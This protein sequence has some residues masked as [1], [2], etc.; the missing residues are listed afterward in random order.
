MIK[1]WTEEFKIHYSENALKHFAMKL[2]KIQKRQFTQE[3][4]LEFA[5]SICSSHSW[6]PWK[7]DEFSKISI[8]EEEKIICDTWFYTRCTWLWLKLEIFWNFFE[9][10]NWMFN[11]PSKVTLVFLFC[12]NYFGFRPAQVQMDAISI[13]L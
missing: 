4:L 13:S 10:N 2:L 8:F 1:I 7:D 3:S 9:H 5:I 11:D 6:G 12:K